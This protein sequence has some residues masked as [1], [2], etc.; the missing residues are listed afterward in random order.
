MQ[1]F[2]PDYSSLGLFLRI[3]VP[4]TPPRY[5]CA[6]ER[7][8]DAEV[9]S[10]VSSCRGRQAGGGGGGRQRGRRGNDKHEHGGSWGQLKIAQGRRGEKSDGGT[11][12]RMEREA[13]AR[14]IFS[15]FENEMFR[16]WNRG[17]VERKKKKEKKKKAFTA[18]CLVPLRQIKQWLF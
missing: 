13:E 12:G 6:R 7:A 11:A 15:G 10:V 8:H 16:S 3:F 17:E 5:S 1:T 2:Q 14:F 4:F 9:P 18:E